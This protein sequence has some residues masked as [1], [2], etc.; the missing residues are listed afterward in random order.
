M[1]RHTVLHP[2]CTAS[3]RLTHPQRLLTDR[4]ADSAWLSCSELKFN[5]VVLGV[6]SAGKTT[7]INTLKGGERLSNLIAPQR[8]GSAGE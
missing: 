7:M 2:L 6:D 8:E 5:V 1:Y 4:S 3:H